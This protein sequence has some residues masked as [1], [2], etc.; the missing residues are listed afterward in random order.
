[1]HTHMY[2]SL[3]LSLLQFLWLLHQNDSSV[4]WKDSDT[5]LDSHN[6]AGVEGHSINDLKL[7]R[8]NTHTCTYIYI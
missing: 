6:D 4:Y 2:S 1:M 5:K 3:S 8:K 7:T